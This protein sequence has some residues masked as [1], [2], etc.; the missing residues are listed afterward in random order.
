VRVRGQG[1]VTTDVGNDVPLAFALEANEPNPFGRQTTI[2]YALAK[3]SHT[4][5]EVF[6]LAGR[7]VTTLA[8]GE[9]AAGRYTVQFRPAAQKELA[10]GVYFVRLTAGTFE[11]TR[12]MLYL[13]R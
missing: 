5:L 13:A 6:D 10:S 12:K 3:A 8:D 11:Q 9:K 7:H 1:S 4:R 2:R